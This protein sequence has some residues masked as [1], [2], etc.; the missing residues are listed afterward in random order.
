M[1]LLLQEI[2][3]KILMIY[4]YIYLPFMGTIVQ[5]ISLIE[6]GNACLLIF[7]LQSLCDAVG[8][9]N[10]KESRVREA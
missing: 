2:L 6:F 9:S 5:S 1:L 10:F 3:F 7:I 8:V 4:I